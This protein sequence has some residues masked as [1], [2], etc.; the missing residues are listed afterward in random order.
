MNNNPLLAV[1][2]MFLLP[3][4]AVLLPLWLGQRYGIYVRKSGDIQDSPVGSAVGATLGLFAFML[5]FTFQIVG[6]RYEKRKELS[7]EEISGIRTT[8]LYAGLI[9]EPYRSETRKHILRFVDLRIEL[10]KDLSKFRQAK[11]ESQQILD[12]LWSY[13]ET[14]AAQDRSSEAY[15]LY[16]ASV[17]DLVKL[18]NQRVTIAQIRIPPLVL[19]VLSFVAFFSTM[20]LGYQFGINGKASFLMIFLLGIVFASVM[21]LIFALDHPESGLIKISD[22]PL[23]ELYQ[24]FHRR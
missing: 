12:S 7:V 13:S 21:W 8:Y 23:K 19:Y 9:P 18:F 14:L 15:S 16:T 2:W 10:Q 24:Q 20:M 17:G 1:A 22:V 4:L 6:D 11:V 3:L 5:G